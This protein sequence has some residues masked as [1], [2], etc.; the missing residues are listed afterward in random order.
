MTESVDRQEIISDMW[1]EHICFLLFSLGP[2][3]TCGVEK[4][5]CECTNSNFFN[6]KIDSGSYRK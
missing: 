6:I 5:Y 1:E 2:C 3:P 4:N